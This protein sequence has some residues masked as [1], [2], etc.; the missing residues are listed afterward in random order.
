MELQRCST[1]RRWLK[2]P[3]ST[4][5]LCM[6]HELGCEPLVHEYFRRAVRF[7]N[8]L[9][10]LPDTSVYKAALKQNIDDGLTTPRPA[11]NFAAALHKALGL[12]LPR[13]LRKLRT[14][15]PIDMTDLEAS[16]ACKYKELTTR[17]S[18]CFKGEGAKIGL[19]FREVAKHEM[20]VVPRYYSFHLSHGVLIR[21]LRFRLGCHHLR[22]NTGRWESVLQSD[23]TTKKLKR[24]ER[25]CRRCYQS[26]TVDD[27][28][29]CL[30][31]CSYHDLRDMREDVLSAVKA[32]GGR[33]ATAADFWATLESIQ[34][35]DLCHR[36]LHF[37]ALCVRV[38]WRCY[39]AGGCDREIVPRAVL[40]AL[41]ADLEPDPVELGLE[42]DNFDSTS[43]SDDDLA[44]N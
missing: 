30:L 31:E 41:P 29:H 36:L 38:S 23:G 27:E 22:V 17:L 33:L 9:V 42:R 40:D 10:A 21:F 37:I 1:L 26:E 7:Y 12:F 16:L 25:T 32:R 14:L 39:K 43:G 2:L 11:V 4:P 44:S 6:L 5:K 28:T 15:E 20:G 8:T 35:V 34:D 3:K 13:W 18:Q 19:Y 24:E